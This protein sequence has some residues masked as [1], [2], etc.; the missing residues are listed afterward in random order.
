MTIPFIK[1]QQR[2]EPG[3]SDIFSYSDILFIG[4]RKQPAYPGR[5]I[6]QQLTDRLPC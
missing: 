5:F 6:G 2:N 4:E 1:A 3:L